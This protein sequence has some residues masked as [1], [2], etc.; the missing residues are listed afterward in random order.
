[1]R[2]LGA[3][4]LSSGFASSHFDGFGF[5]LRVGKVEVVRMDEMDVKSWMLGMLVDENL[6]M[7]EKEVGSTI[8]LSAGG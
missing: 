1:L 5:G 6:W 7:K 4:G 3:A 8:Y 2:V